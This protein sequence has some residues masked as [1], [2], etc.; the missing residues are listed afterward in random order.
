MGTLSGRAWRHLQSTECHGGGVYELMYRAGA[1]LMAML[2][3][4]LLLL[5]HLAFTALLA[6][7]AGQHVDLLAAGTISNWTASTVGGV[8]PLDR[9]ASTAFTARD[10]V[11]APVLAM[12]LRLCLSVCLSQVGVLPKRLNES[13]QGR[14]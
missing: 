6:R 7:S 8:A 11:L 1:E 9:S 2:V 13:N 12:A 3:G 14:I 10:A 4:T 5:H